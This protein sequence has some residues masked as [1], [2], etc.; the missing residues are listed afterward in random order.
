VLTLDATEG[1]KTCQR[2]SPFHASPSGAESGP[3]CFHLL[4]HFRWVR[5]YGTLFEIGHARETPSPCLGLARALPARRR[6]A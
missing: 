3:E 1:P 4:P 2:E 6:E 5:S